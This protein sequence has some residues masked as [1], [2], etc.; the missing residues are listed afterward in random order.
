MEVDDILD[1]Y[2]ILFQQLVVKEHEEVK[3]HCN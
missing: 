3:E 1:L 2:L